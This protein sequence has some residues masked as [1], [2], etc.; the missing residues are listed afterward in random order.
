LAAFQI[1]IIVRSYYCG[2]SV[3]N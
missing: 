2:R 3:G 1:L